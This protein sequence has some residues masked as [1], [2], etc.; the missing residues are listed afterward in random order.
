MAIGEKISGGKYEKQNIYSTDTVH[1]MCTLVVPSFK[2]DFN[3]ERNKSFLS[4][5]LTMLDL[6]MLALLIN[7]V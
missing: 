3:L 2:N 6:L 1:E 5:H 7:L 4:L